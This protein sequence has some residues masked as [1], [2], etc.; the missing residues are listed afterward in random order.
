MCRF[1]KSLLT[2]R[3]KS[4]VVS[5]HIKNSPPPFYQSPER[6]LS[7]RVHNETLDFRTPPRRRLTNR[8]V[9]SQKEGVT[10]NLSRTEI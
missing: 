9:F 4:A 10:D 5:V 1:K 8:N 6:L 7:P 3:L 2:N